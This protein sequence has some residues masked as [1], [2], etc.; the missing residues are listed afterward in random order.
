MVQPRGAQRASCAP[1]C[2]IA[3]QDWKQQFAGYY[4]TASYREAQRAEDVL[5]TSLKRY[6]A[7]SQD[8]SAADQATYVLSIAEAKITCN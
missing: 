5:E 1:F 6:D 8:N 7:F 3:A 4:D 2:Y